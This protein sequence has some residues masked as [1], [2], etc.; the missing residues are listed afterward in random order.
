MDKIKGFHVSKD[1]KISELVEKYESLGFQATQISKAAK[2]IRKMRKENATIFLTF[3]SNMVSSGLR[4]IFAQMAKEKMVDAIITSVGSIEEDLI[5][6]KKPFLL[7]SFDAD[8]KDL[9]EKNINR[10]G[11]IYVPTGHY[12]ALEK[13]LN[14]F[15]KKMAEK[16][17]K[18]G[19]IS[20]Q[21][22]IYELGK[23]IQDENSILY[24]ATKNNIPIFCPAITDGAFGLQL[25]Y[26]KQKHE[27]GIDVTADMNNLADIVYNAKKTGA[28]ILGGGVAKH[29]VL[30]VNLVRGGLNYA[31]YVSTATEFDGS[32]SGARPKEAVSWHKINQ[33]NNS[34][35]V[36]A[37]ATVVFP[38]ILGGV[39]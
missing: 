21:E 37:D 11:N 28:I 22:L 25:Y 29:H 5:K 9:A 26:F 20:P 16:Q 32:L 14:P 30:G 18:D 34:V 31:V 35:F 15:F 39:L 12:E 4:E 7:G 2:L 13:M 38:L 1:M 33:E 19:M 27:I 23:E 17:K 3:T 8:D 24:W 6:T 36:Y 10:I